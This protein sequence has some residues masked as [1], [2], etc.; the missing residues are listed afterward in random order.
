MPYLAIDKKGNEWI[1]EQDVGRVHCPHACSVKY[2]FIPL[3]KGMI[4]LLIGR[5]LH[6]HSE[7]VFFEA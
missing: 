4:K 7:P 2:N 1:Y 5:D 3:K 6:Q